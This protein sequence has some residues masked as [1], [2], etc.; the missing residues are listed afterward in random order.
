MMEVSSIT[1]FYITSG[2]RRTG[3]L[4]VAAATVHYALVFPNI[5]LFC[6]IVSHR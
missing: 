6:I 1:L 2:K 5:T 3:S 4:F